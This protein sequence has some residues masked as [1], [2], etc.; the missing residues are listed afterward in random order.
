MA[1]SELIYSFESIEIVQKA[2]QALT[3]F[4]V[5]QPKIR[6]KLF[7]HNMQFKLGEIY[8]RLKGNNT[9]QL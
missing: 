3:N 8:E 4:V 7:E 1:L 6:E 2:I 5:D 9:C